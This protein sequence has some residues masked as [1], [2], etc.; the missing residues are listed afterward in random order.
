MENG[1]I[2]TDSNPRQTTASASSLAPTSDERTPG[3]VS[4]RP[5][6]ALLRATWTPRTAIQGFSALLACLVAVVAWAEEAEPDRVWTQW[7]GANQAFEAPSGELA[8]SWGEDGPEEIW[9][10]ELGEGYSAIL[11]EDAKLYTMYRAD[12][13]EVVASLDAATGKTL[14]THSYES[15]PHEQH[16]NQ[17]G[18]GP[19]GT[20]LLVG[21]TI[22]TIGISGVMHALDKATGEPKWKHDL[23]T[24]FGGSF[25]NHGYSSSPIAYRDTVIVL[26]GGENSS[27]VAFDRKDG[28]VRWKSGSFGNSYSTPRLFDVGGKPLLVTFMAAE[29]VGMDPDTG[30][31]HWTH[32]HQNQWGQNI[33][34][35]VL[36]DGQYLFFSAPQAGAKGVKLTRGEDGKTAIEELWSTRKIQFYHVTSVLD[37]KHVYGS[38]GTGAPSFMASV[39]VETGEINWRERGFA[40]ANVLAADGK[41]I[42]LDEDGVLYLASA[43]ETALEVHSKFTLFEEGR[44]WTV[45]TVVGTTLY[46]R[47]SHRIV[48]LDLG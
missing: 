41:L 11:V 44:A 8:D 47:D 33:N 14:W 21:D 43:D 35:P 15:D 20:P 42:V 19:R 13:K 4:S 10:R 32:G 29:L 25:L 31:V 40:K 45:P 5:T 28:T 46:A 27:V 34:Q 17:F 37:G 22:Y 1:K 7:G 16:V 24:D 26:V 39:N 36:V 2:M 48:A 18:R 30:E 9:S 3:L 12:E 23:W 6:F 38:T